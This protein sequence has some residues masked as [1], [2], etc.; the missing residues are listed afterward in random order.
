MSLG[1]A[2]G[3]EPRPVT[4]VVSMGLGDPPST[5]RVRTRLELYPDAALQ[6]RPRPDWTDELIAELAGPARSTRS[7]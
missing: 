1:E 4:F 7:T 3:R 2:V 5:E 6:A